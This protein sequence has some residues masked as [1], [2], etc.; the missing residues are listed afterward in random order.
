MKLGDYVLATRW[1][2]GSPHDP[3]AVG[4]LRKVE[5]LHLPLRKRSYCVQADGYF[6][7]CQKIS[8]PEG[9]WLLQHRDDLSASVWACLRALRAERKPI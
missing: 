9:Q 1:S 3:W 8:G 7:R 2:D 6:R 4:Y 5:L